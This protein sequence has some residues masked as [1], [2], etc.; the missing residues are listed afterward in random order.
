[1]LMID[2]VRQ[3]LLAAG[4]DD[5]IRAFP[6]GTRSAQDAAQAIDCSVAQIA[7]SIV[8]RSGE[9]VVLVI[10]SGAH[11]IDRGKVAGLIGRPVKPADPAWVR[12][13]TGFAVGGVAPVGHEC[14]VTTV[15]DSALLALSPLWAAAG[16]PSHVFRTTAPQLIAMTGGTVGEVRQD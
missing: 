13:R 12:E 3:A 8:F 6:E 1:M 16:S 7:K 14:A 10:A 11:R 5:T 9:E 15:I 4:H 2:T